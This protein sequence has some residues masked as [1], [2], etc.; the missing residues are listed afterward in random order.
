MEL[1]NMSNNFD[2]AYH[3]LPQNNEKQ[4]DWVASMTK[5]LAKKDRP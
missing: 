4:K 5:L 3:P 1:S 2:D